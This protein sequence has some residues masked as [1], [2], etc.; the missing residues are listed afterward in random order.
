M[1]L[2]FQPQSA[3]VHWPVVQNLYC[4][5]IVVLLTEK[6]EVIVRTMACDKCCCVVKLGRKPV[7]LYSYYVRH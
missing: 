3:A 2:S 6:R 4:L 7:I 5:M 1:Q